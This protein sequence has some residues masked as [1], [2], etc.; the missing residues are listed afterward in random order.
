MGQFQ[1]TSGLALLVM[2]VLLEN[3]KVEKIRGFI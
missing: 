2:P 3:K 1:S